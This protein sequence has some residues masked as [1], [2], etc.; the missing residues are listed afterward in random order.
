MQCFPPLIS[1]FGLLWLIHAEYNM[2]GQKK[3]KP[4][5]ILIICAIGF[6]NLS[7]TSATSG[8]PRMKAAQKMPM[9]VE[10]SVKIVGGKPDGTDRGIINGRPA[11]LWDAA[12]QFEKPDIVVCIAEDNSE[13]RCTTECSDSYSCVFAP[14]TVSSEN[15]EIQVWDF[16]LAEHDIIGENACRIDTLCIVGQA[17]VTVKRTCK[18]GPAVDRSKITKDILVDNPNEN[19]NY[20]LIR[21]G[22]FEIDLT[23]KG[24]MLGDKPYGSKIISQQAISFAEAKMKACFGIDDARLAGEINL[25]AAAYKASWLNGR[26]NPINKRANP[27][28]VDWADIDF[29]QKEDTRNKSI[30]HLHASLN[31]LG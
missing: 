27:V 11:M 10:I 15:F 5:L 26:P 31:I 4:N 16:D 17:Q 12:S 1:T 21:P 13:P 8:Q 9:E 22:G 28:N 19:I 24:I 7:L 25:H 30:A 20:I 14:F 29:K 2:K 3:M 18:Y 6:L 23:P